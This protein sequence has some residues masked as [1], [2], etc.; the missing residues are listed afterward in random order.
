VKHV[1]NLNR[2]FGSK[3]EIIEGIVFYNAAAK[4]T[5]KAPT[6]TEV[7]ASTGRLKEAVRFLLREAKQTAFADAIE[8]YL[9]MLKKT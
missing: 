1:E 9:K 3:K 6:S 5:G 4:F 2:N 7:R 8:E